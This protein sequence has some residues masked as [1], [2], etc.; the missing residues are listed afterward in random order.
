MYVP[1]ALVRMAPWLL[2]CGIWFALLMPSA[3]ATAPPRFLIFHV[4]GV[5][6][7]DFDR[8][9]A[10]GRLPNIEQAFAGGARA[11]ASSLFFAVTPVIYP[12]M[13][14]GESNA[15][16]GW[17]GFGG[18]DRE[19]GRPISEAAVFFDYVQVFPR[20]SLA[21]MLYGAPLLDALAGLAMQNLPD[22]LERYRVVEFFWFSTDTV[23][24]LLGAE[25]QARSLERF[26]AYLGRLLPRLD[27]E[28]LNLVLYADH[29]LSF[30][31]GMVDLEPALL[32]RVGAERLHYVYPNLFLHDPSL[33]PLLARELSRPGGPDFAFY[34]VDAKRVH[35]YVD[36]AFVRFE[37]EA[38]GIR[39]L[40]DDDPLGYAEIGYDGS[41]LTPDEWLALTIDAPFPATPPNVFGYV[42]NPDAGDVVMGLNPPRMPVTVRA[43]AGAHAGLSHTDLVVPVL[44]RGPGLEALAARSELWLHELYRDIPDLAFGYEPPRE[45]HEVEAWMRF[46]DL[47]PCLR[48]RLSPAYRLRLGAEA[49]PVS[50]S[51]WSEHDV[52]ASYLTRW[53]LGAGVN[54]QRGEVQPMVRAEVEIDVGDARLRIEGRYQPCGWTFGLGA[55]FRVS[56]AMRVSWS[57]PGG[58][59][60]GFDW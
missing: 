47:V 5:A 14:S 17:L 36:G 43:P 53:W 49:S 34:R 39:Y 57:A 41:A 7:V 15:G 10:E 20:R 50:W 55:T 21:S 19:A 1:T 9:L 24:H 40:S 52:M 27:M 37:A 58:V 22:L 46:D 25:A 16:P 54:Y 32:E 35:G 31:R 8:A 60:I 12:R 42:Q 11:D 13:H 29:G 3:L 26:D 30:M 45:R 51:L 38:D 18:Y 2:G 56:E 4:D 33:A 48:A 23:G 6:A 44:S 28:G 59:G